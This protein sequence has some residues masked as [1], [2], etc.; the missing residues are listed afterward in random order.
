MRTG[1]CWA[2]LSAATFRQSHMQ[3]QKR[4]G[5]QK[6]LCHSEDLMPSRHGGCSWEAFTGCPATLVHVKQRAAAQALQNGGESGMGQSC[7]ASHPRH[8]PGRLCC[9][10]RTAPV[11]LAAQTVCDSCYRHHSPA[12]CF[13]VQS[14]PLGE[15]F[16][17][18]SYE[19][20]ELQRERHSFVWEG[21]LHKEG[22]SFI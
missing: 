21:G 14:W 2:L 20:A 9:C 1:S 10:L 8:S 19:E 6:L 7:S 22:H 3:P 18:A 11:L 16:L 4:Q 12:A 13:G 17:A 15:N 5:K